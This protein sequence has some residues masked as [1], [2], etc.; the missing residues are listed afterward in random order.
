VILG[1]GTDISD[2]SRMRD[3]LERSGRS[4]MN[5]LFTEA[6]QARCERR[7]DPVPCLA[8]R[9]AAKEALGK[10]LGVGLG[11]MGIT[12]AEVV[13]DERG[14]PS[15]RFHGRLKSWVEA[16]PGMR[17]HLTLSDGESH[18]AAFVVLESDQIDA[19]PSFPGVREQE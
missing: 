13:N 10:A 16:V 6:E 17:V 7:H 9:F 11:S 19:L 2:F 15:F 8:A 4:L 18:A 14:A 1:I 5:R 3:A 12:S